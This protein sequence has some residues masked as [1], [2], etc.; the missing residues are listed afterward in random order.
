MFAAGD[1]YATEVRK[2]AVAKGFHVA[3]CASD[4]PRAPAST[5]EATPEEI[6]AKRAEIYG[7]ERTLA[8]ADDELRSAMLRCPKA[9]VRLCFDHAEPLAH[10]EDMLKHGLYLLSLHYGFVK[11]GRHRA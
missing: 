6:E 2:V 5:G 3:G 11:R 10:D 4:A 8:R 9:M 1:A 7:L